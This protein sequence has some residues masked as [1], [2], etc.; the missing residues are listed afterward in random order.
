[1]CGRFGFDIPKAI[2]EERFGVEPG[3]IGVAEITPSW[4]IAPG[5]PILA[6]SLFEGR[7]ELLGYTWGLVPTWARDTRRGFINARSETAHDKPSFK[8]SLRHHR[9]LV[10]AS[11][12]YEWKK[13][14][15]GT[16]PHA[17]MLENRAPFA[18]AGIFAE[19]PLA[20]PTLALLTTTPNALMTPIHDRMPVVL[21]PEAYTAWL[22]PFAHPQDIQSLLVPY[23]GAMHAQAVSIR[24]NSTSENNPGLLNPVPEIT[25]LP[26]D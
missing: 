10:P 11:F 12:F 1:M 24:V 19:H 17:I 3:S 23:K 5:Q 21:P 18:M 13:T 14:S 15:S 9:C 6:V 20:G 2:L 25:S 7:R 22:D 26:L 4:N 16:L 8:E